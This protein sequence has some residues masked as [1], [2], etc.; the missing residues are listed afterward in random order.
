MR[1]DDDHNL[2]VDSYKV[3]WKKGSGSWETPADVTEAGYA[4]SGP[5][6]FESYVI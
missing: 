6:F 5:S 4:P 1:N 3:Q 2:Y